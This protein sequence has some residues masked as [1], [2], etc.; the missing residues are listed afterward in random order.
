MKLKLIQD[1]KSKF[2]YPIFLQGSLGED[3][4]YPDSFFTFWNY[5]TEPIFY[6]DDVQREKWSFWLYFY[7][8]DPT[9]TNTILK[10]AQKYLRELGYLVGGSSDAQSDEITHTGRMCSIAYIKEEK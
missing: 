6:D 3:K 4:A 5:E 2:D 9:L 7:S 10:E 8:N 1:L